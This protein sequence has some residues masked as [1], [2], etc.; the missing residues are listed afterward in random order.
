MRQD[1]VL[2]QRLRQRADF[3]LIAANQILQ[4]GVGNL[5]QAIHEELSTNPALELQTDQL[6]PACGFP[7]RKG[8]CRFCSKLA[9]VSD[10][11]EAGEIFPSYTPLPREKAPQTT[12]GEVSEMAAPVSLGE[13]LRSQAQAALP[14]RDYPIAD[15]LIANI[16]DRGLLQCELEEVSQELKRPREQVE[17]VLEVLQGLDPLGVGARDPQEALLVQIRSLAQ[18]QE[19]DPRVETIVSSYWTELAN[20]RYEKIAHKL[21]CNIAEVEQAVT[22]ILNNLNPYPGS[23]FIVRGPNRN[24]PALRWPDLV[25]HREKDDYRVE[26]VESFESE[27][28]ISEAFLKLRQSL[29]G[30]LPRTGKEAAALESLRRACFFLSCLKM[31]KKTLEEVGSAVVKLQRGFLDTGLEAHLRPLTRAKVGSLL[32][33]HESTISRAVAD[34]FVLL[35]NQQLMPFE[36]FFA[37]SAGPKS[38]IRDL[39]QREGRGRSLTDQQLAQILAS[40]GYAIARRT[41]TKYRLALRIPASHQRKRRSGRK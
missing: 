30:S 17:K 24:E 8:E 27:L 39:I 4:K 9:F 28:R 37:R 22:F 21:N 33:K 31:R 20:H 3:R 36:K 10:E 40:R 7:L 18:E 25:I 19:V 6:C 15:Y 41:V 14:A 26:V 23:G 29:T 12:S 11:P 5:Q 16:D 2:R 1:Q 32:G 38:I 13:H 34:K 35:P